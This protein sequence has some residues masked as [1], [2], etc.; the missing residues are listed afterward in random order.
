MLPFALLGIFL[1]DLRYFD[2]ATSTDLLNRVG[3]E[4]RSIFYYWVFIILLEFVLRITE[5]YFKGIYNAIKNPQRRP[6][7]RRRKKE[8]EEAVEESPS[9]EVQEVEEV[10]ERRPVGAYPIRPQEAD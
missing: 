8:M 7:R 10:E 1:I 2:A 5:P 6:A 3:V 9:E 4:W